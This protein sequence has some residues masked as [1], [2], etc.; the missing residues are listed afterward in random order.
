MS[1]EGSHEHGN[2][3]SHGHS[4]GHGHGEQTE[5]PEAGVHGMLMVGEQ[6]LYLSHLPMF[7]HPKHDVQAILEVH[8]TDEDA[9]ARYVEDRRTS[10]ELVY[11][12][13]PEHFVLQHLVTP[14]PEGECLCE[15][16]GT[17]YRGHFER[18]GEPILPELKL[19][20]VV[21]HV[22]HFRQFDPDAEDLVIQKYI[23]FGKGDEQFLAHLITKPPDFDQVLSVRI[24][25]REFSDEELRR[26]PIL[27]FSRRA[28]DSTNRLQPGEQTSASLVDDSGQ[29]K[30][31]VGTEFYIE[32]GDLAG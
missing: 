27:F 26:G 11:T 8:L 23:L 10:G 28:N 5:F 25:G 32:E 3:H 6:T 19:R 4:H 14:E 18:G 30:L 29:V 31:E 7:N 21:D 9:H 15:F 20:F 13:E 12:L 16:T 22:V 1:G 2:S 17:L 24:S